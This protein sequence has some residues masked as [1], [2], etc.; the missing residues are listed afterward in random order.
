MLNQKGA[1]AKALGT[2]S[3]AKNTNKTETSDKSAVSGL[4]QPSKVLFLGTNLL[5]TDPQ[6]YLS[7]WN[8]S[9]KKR[10]KIGG[11]AV[12]VL[13]NLWIWVRLHLLI[14]K[15]TYP[16]LRSNVTLYAIIYCV[17]GLLFAIGQTAVKIRILRKENEESLSALKL[18]AALLLSNFLLGYSVGAFCS[19]VYFITSR[20]TQD[21][22]FMNQYIMMLDVLGGTCMLGF[23]IFRGWDVAFR[24]TSKHSDLLD[25]SKPLL[26]T[27]TRIYY[28]Y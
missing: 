23:N 24:L 13:F 2:N 19:I 10:V 3:T 22:S 20:I 9:S 8:V 4:E 11:F 7:F 25:F 27:A 1:A 15:G 26:E 21:F 28:H 16:Y 12:A 6:S 14:R 17:I 5:K 18:F